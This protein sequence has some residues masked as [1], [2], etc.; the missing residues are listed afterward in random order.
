MGFV[1]CPII[2]GVAPVEWGLRCRYNLS[3][4]ISLLSV[5]KGEEIEGGFLCSSVKRERQ[6]KCFVL[7]AFLFSI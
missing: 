3:C 6:S 5:Q 4:T 1:S 7:K 2:V